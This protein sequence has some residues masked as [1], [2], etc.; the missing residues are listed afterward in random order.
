MRFSDRSQAGQLLAQALN[1]Y[2]SNPGVVVLALPRGG[3]PVGFEVACALNVPLDIIVV[4]KLGVPDR[5]ELA[6]GAIASGDVRVL[7]QE[8]VDW[9]QISPAVI[10][11]VIELE[12][13]ELQRRERVY[14]GAMPPL[15]IAGK[16]AVLVD[17]GIATGSTMRAAVEV[18]RSRNPRRVVIAVP[19]APASTIKELRSVVDDFVSVIS[20][21]AFVGVGQWYQDFRQVSDEITRDLYERARLQH[22]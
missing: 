10:D 6:M 21:D 7:N 18:V 8:I 11:R 17:D 4:R 19:T 9:L 14:R 20:S 12:T 15:E 13:M 1:H 2:A 3:V 16:I 22:G 5:V